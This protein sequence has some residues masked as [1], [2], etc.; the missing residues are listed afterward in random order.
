M[1]TDAE[2]PHI[3]VG[4]EDKDV[5]ALKI[6]PTATT[7]VPS[8]LCAGTSTR[9]MA[10]S[11]L[12]NRMIISFPMGLASTPQPSTQSSYTSVR[13]LVERRHRAAYAYPLRGFDANVSQ[14]PAVLRTASPG[15]GPNDG[16]DSNLSSHQSEKTF[17]YKEEPVYANEEP[18][19]NNQ[20]KV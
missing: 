16:T 6:Q 5:L 10:P 1:T 9:S 14:D 2:E 12:E 19:G 13:R 7:S 18:Q 20:E 11:K 3:N 8:F 4:F 15:L 17:T